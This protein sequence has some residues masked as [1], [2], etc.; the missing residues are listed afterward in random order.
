MRL[1]WT[2][3]LR[4]LRSRAYWSERATLSRSSFEVQDQAADSVGIRMIW[5]ASC[6]LVR[7]SWTAAAAETGCLWT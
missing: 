7:R 4:M 2:R 3:R 6:A 1:D 5:T